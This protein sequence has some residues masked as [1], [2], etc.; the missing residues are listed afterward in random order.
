M[1]LRDIR[2]YRNRGAPNLANQPEFLVC[3]KHGCKTIDVRD[4]IDRFFPNLQIGIFH[5]PGSNRSIL[6]PESSILLLN[7]LN[8]F[9]HLLDQ[10]L[11]IKRHARHFD[12][13]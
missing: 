6:D 5:Q 4:Q 8:L 7:V 11:E 12:V 13:D 10:E 9:P 3:W 1:S 2:G